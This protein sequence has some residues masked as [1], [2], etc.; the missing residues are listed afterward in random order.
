MPVSLSIDIGGTFTDAVLENDSKPYDRPID[1][2]KMSHLK[3]K[4]QPYIQFKGQ[5]KTYFQVEEE[6]EFSIRK[7]TSPSDLIKFI[8]EEAFLKICL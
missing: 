6:K 2:M 3:M 8:P 4:E 5:A 1:F 7:N